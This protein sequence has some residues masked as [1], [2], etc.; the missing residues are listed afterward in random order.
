MSNTK[1][2]DKQNSTDRLSIIH[3]NSLGNRKLLNKDEKCGCFH[4][5]RIFNTS[6]IYEWIREY[7]NEETAICPHCG[8]D[9]I[10]SD[11]HGEKLSK[12]LLAEMHRKYFCFRG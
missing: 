7:N 6:E 11:S 10:I 5:G 8:V 1:I 4:C 3:K 9:S 2:L 12:K